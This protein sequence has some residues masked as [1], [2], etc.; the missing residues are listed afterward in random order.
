MGVDEEAVPDV[1]RTAIAM[2]AAQGSP[3]LFRQRQAEFATVAVSQVHERRARPREDFLTQLVSMEVEGRRLDD[4]DYVVLLAAFLGAGHHST[5]SAI[6][7]LI[8]RV[9]SDPTMADSL[10]A[11]PQRITAAIEETL[12][13]HP[14]FFGFFRRTKRPVSVADVP[15]P[16]G[17]DV[18]MGWAAANR[19]SQKFAAP[20]EFKLDRGVNQ[21]L[22]FGFGIHT[23]PGAAVARMELRVVLEELLRRLPDLR[24]AIDKPSYQFGG[25]DYCF[26]PSL[27]VTFTS[28]PAESPKP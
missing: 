20:T 26:I 3:E 2:F 4:D 7:S 11:D 19:D 6:A 14:P 16:Q 27:P 15:M 25:G 13:L 9:F 28:G 23:C 8:F 17:A 22:T 12:R 24:V 21:H 5:T 18:Y 1:R 10:R